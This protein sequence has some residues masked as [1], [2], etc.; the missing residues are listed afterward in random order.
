MNSAVKMRCCSCR[1]GKFRLQ[2][3]L[4]VPCQRLKADQCMDQMD[5]HIDISQQ[6]QQQHHHALFMYVSVLCPTVLSSM[7]ISKPEGYSQNLDKGATSTHWLLHAWR[8]QD[9]Q[10][11]HASWRCLDIKVMVE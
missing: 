10:K 2:L 7:L 6:Q 8:S 9:C 11:L 3:S 1:E 5:S 4:Q